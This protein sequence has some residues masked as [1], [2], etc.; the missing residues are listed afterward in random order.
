MV[1]TG[2]GAVISL[3]VVD[4]VRSGAEGGGCIF[5]FLL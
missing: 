4:T 1:V 5:L 3:A 2:S